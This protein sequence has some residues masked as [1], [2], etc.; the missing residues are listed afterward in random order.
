MPG[1]STIAMVAPGHSSGL[2]SAGSQL[3]KALKD[4]V[5]S[6]SRWNPADWEKLRK[7]EK[8]VGEAIYMNDLTEFVEQ[9]YDAP[10]VTLP[11]GDVSDISSSPYKQKFFKQDGEGDA[12][13]REVA[14][15]YAGHNKNLCK[16]VRGTIDFDEDT[17]LGFPS[18]PHALSC[19]FMYLHALLVA[20]HGSPW[21]V[22]KWVG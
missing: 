9:C 19:T 21:G 15:V 1:G 17:V 5:F 3:T 7:W 4:I 10:P 8:V 12:A 22:S 13:L 16:V 6:S 14:K 18:Q 2:G 11:G 20:G